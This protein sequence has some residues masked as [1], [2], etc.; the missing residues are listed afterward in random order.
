MRIIRFFLCYVLVNVFVLLVGT[1]LAQNVRVEHLTFFGLNVQT[2]FVWIL[3]GAA[4]FGFLAASM[5]LIPGR[6][7]VSLRV[8]EL[9]REASQLEKQV[10]LLEEQRED[11]I[12]RHEVLVQARE[13]ALDRYHHL[14]AEYNN[15]LAR[16]DEPRVEVA[17]SKSRTLEVKVPTARPKASTAELEALA[18]ESE[19]LVE[20]ESVSGGPESETVESEAPAT[21]LTV[22]SRPVRMV[23][24]LA[25]PQR[26]QRL[27]PTL[28]GSSVVD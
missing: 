5:L 25:L 23:E 24:Q 16:R 7:I 28:P 8:W 15:L 3:L 1:F 19:S 6:V 26:L 2:N 4:T 14:L 18:T 11:L 10:S 13:H 22:L 20:P 21:V 17:K 12:V 27:L 9:D